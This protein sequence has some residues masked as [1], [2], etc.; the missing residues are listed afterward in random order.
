[1]ESH[2]IRNNTFQFNQEV[3]D[4]IGL[5]IFFMFAVVNKIMRAIELQ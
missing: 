4:L 2:A 5:F 1:M 3:D